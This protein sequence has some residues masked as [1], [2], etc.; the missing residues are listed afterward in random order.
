PPLKPPWPSPESRM[1]VPSSTPAG[2]STASVFSFCTWPAPEHG[3]HG[4]LMKRPLPRQLGQV[5]SMV[6]KPCC[7]RTLPMPEQLGHCSTLEPASAPVPP[8]AS[9]ATALGTLI[10]ALR[11][12]KASSSVIVRL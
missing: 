4:L 6:K 10:C 9:H 5:R 12:L 3:L 11:P 7:A 2:M 1:R 8:H